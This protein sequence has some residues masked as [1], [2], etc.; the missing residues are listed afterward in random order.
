MS[1]QITGWNPDD[2]ETRYHKKLVKIGRMGCSRSAFFF[3]LE[4]GHS[5]QVFGGPIKLGDKLLC[6]QCAEIAAQKALDN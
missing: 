5:G 3:T 1:V 6:A 4:C 2:P